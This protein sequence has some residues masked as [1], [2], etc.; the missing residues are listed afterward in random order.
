MDATIKWVTLARENYKRPLIHVCV[1]ENFVEAM[2][3]DGPYTHKDYGVTATDAA[4]NRWH[5]I[6][7]F[8]TEDEAIDFELK[9]DD[10]LWRGGN[11]NMEH[12]FR[13][14]SV[15]GSDAYFARNEESALAKLDVEAEY[16]PGSY[17][18]GGPG[19]IG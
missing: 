17:H 18:P 16:G 8:K 19:Y 2:G 9:I 6:A 5:H 13:G 11:L 7:L 15:Y 14:V 1:R 3:E 10:H 12:W 4:G